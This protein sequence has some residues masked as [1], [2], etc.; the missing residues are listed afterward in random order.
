[1]P[2]PID[3]TLGMLADNMRRRQSALPVG[4]RVVLEWTRGLGLPRGGPTVL[5][6]GQM[7]QMV[8]AI[9]AMAH[10]LARYE[11]GSNPRLF[12][13]ARSMNRLVNL[14]P[15]LARTRRRDRAAFNDR[16]RNIVRLLRTAGAE[17]GYLFEDDL[18]TGALA[19]DEGLDRGFARHAALVYGKLRAHGVRSVITVD[20]HTTHMLRSVYPKV[21]P[22]YELEVHSYLEVLAAL[23]PAP[24]RA[25]GESATF[26]DSCL[27]ARAEGIVEPPRQLLAGGGVTVVEPEMSGKLTFCCGGP[28]ETLFP[29]RSAE[30]AQRR[31]DQLARASPRIVTACPLCLANL[32]R[33]RKDGVEV[34]DISDYLVRAY[35]PPTPAVA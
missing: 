4:R 13:F 24:L 3:S 35:C 34:R 31:L 28:I 32:S 29:G 18:Y 16:L 7:W 27:Y 19:H 12:R 30:I 20:P 10:E 14:T 8:P 11:N 25:L 9:N 22:D 26:H 23:R 15:L 17:F 33:V 1:M 5:Y 21:V 6:T 2:V